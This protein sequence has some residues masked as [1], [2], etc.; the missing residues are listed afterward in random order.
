MMEHMQ[1]MQGMVGGGMMG[2]MRGGGQG[3]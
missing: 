1:S 3:R 2:G